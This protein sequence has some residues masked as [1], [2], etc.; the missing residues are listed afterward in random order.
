L[1]SRVDEQQKCKGQNCLSHGR[2]VVLSCSAWNLV[3]PFKHTYEAKAPEC[4]EVGENVNGR[5]IMSA[6]T[7][8]HISKILVKESLC[9]VKYVNKSLKEQFGTFAGVLIQQPLDSLFG[10]QHASA[11]DTTLISK[12]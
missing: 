8:Y 6:E 9:S 4:H 11:P 7:F 3:P 5:Q 10:I 2:V 1:R 12:A